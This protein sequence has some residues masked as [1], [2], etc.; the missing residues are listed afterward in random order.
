MEISPREG[1]GGPL[2][3]SS[4]RPSS[5]ALPQ[6]C[7]SPPTP[8][9][10]LLEADRGLLLGS[11]PPPPWDATTKISR[12]GWSGGDPPSPPCPMGHGAAAGV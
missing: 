12:S 10:G 6:G 1:V 7:G 2:L 9:A 11:P 4:S 3:P 8:T 5:C